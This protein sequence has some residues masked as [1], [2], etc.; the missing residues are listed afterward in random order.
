M[1]LILQV[2]ALPGVAGRVQVRVMN[3]ALI[4]AL[5]PP[6]L[7]AHTTAVH[8]LEI[9]YGRFEQQMHYPPMRYELME[10]ALYRMAASCC[11]YGE[12]EGYPRGVEE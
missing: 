1:S 11:D 12:P 8:R 3:G 2:I 4:A 5:R 10:Q 7:N 6:P 9:P